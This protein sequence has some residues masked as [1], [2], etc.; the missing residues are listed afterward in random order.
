MHVKLVRL[1]KTFI[2][3]QLDVMNMARFRLLKE[4]IMVLLMSQEIEGSALQIILGGNIGKPK[5]EQQLCGL[6]KSNCLNTLK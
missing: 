1:L 6:L 4:G 3:I 5:M 2:E